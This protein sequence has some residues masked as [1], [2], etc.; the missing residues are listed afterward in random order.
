MVVIIL[1]V[2]RKRKKNLF[3]KLL[4]TKTI[5]PLIPHQHEYL[6]S[7]CESFPWLY[8]AKF[9][10]KSKTHGPLLWTVEMKNKIKM[11]LPFNLIKQFCLINAVP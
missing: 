9:T 1:L 8:H 2:S 7:F 10:G 4:N 5:F 3:L 11:G 6:V